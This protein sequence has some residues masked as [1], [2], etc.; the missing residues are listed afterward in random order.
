MVGQF[1]MPIDTPDS[2]AA[3]KLP[4]SRKEQVFRAYYPALSVSRSLLSKRYY[5]L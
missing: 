4:A 5:C 3:K 2:I 1:S